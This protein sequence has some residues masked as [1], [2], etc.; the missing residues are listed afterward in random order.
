[1]SKSCKRQSNTFDKSVKSAAKLP[2]LSLIFPTLVD[3]AKG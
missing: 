3:T 2:P 1:M